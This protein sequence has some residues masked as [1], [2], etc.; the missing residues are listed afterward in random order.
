M[1]ADF[2][3]LGLITFLLV[4]TADRLQVPTVAIDQIYAWNNT[5]IMQDEVLCHRIGLVPLKIDPR[6]VH[7]RS[8]FTITNPELVCI[9]MCY[10]KRPLTTT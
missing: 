5:S 2:H 1:F 6:T 7:F 3:F 8:T 10:R 4:T 9:L